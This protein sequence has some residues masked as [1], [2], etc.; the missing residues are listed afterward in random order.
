MSSFGLDMSI[1][2][3]GDA[4]MVGNRLIQSGERIATMKPVMEEIFI[5]MLIGNE[6]NIRSEGRRGGGSYAQLRLNTLR[7]KGSAEILYTRGARPNYT[8]LGDDTLVNSVTQLDADYQAKSVGQAHV[9]LG[10]NRPYA[11]AH[12]HGSPTRRIPRR[13]F[14]QYTQRDVDR[15]NYM[16]RRELMKPIVENW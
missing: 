2:D 16:I 10:T 1:S 14:L 3:S 5:D 13:P 6:A 11:G 8:K 12:Q 4:R 7:K 9:M 15:W